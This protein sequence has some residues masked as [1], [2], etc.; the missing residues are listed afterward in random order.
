MLQMQISSADK[1]FR[2]MATSDLARELKSSH[3][4]LDDFETQKII[5]AVLKQLN[6]SSG[7]ISGLA[8]TCLGTLV[9]KVDAKHLDSMCAVL[10]D[11]MKGDKD[12]MRRDIA[13]LGVKTVIQ[14]IGVYE[15]ARVTAL[16][17]AEF[18]GPRLMACVVDDKEE[19]TLNGYDL[20]LVFLTQH[21]P[22][23]PDMCAIAD[24]CVG[25]FDN[26]RPGIRKKA[27]QCLGKMAASLPGKHFDGLCRK[28][29]E[30]MRQHPGTSAMNKV[31]TMMMAMSY[32]A[33]GAG[34]RMDAHI[35]E[36]LSLCFDFVGAAL[37][38]EDGVDLVESC[39]VVLEL[40]VSKCPG[41]TENKRSD[42]AKVAGRCIR[43]DPNYA[44]DSDMEEDEPLVDSDMG[45]KEE[46]EEGEDY[47]DEDAF[48][49][50]D[51]SS[52]KVRRAA[53]KLICTEVKQYPTHVSDLYD[54]L[55][56]ILIKRAISE[57]EDTVRQ[58]IFNSYLE[59]LKVVDADSKDDELVQKFDRDAEDVVVKFARLVKK[60]TVQT[61]CCV[62][63]ALHSMVVMRPA[64]FSLVLPKLSSDIV[65]CLQED[66]AFA[67]QVQ[68]LE[69][70]EAG[71]DGMPGP[72][73]EEDLVKISEEV[74]ECAKK[75]YFASAA[76]ALKTCRR[77]VHLIRPDVSQ[78]VPQNLAGLVLPLFLTI[79]DVL[80]VS[81]KPQEVKN[82]AIDCAAESLAW[83]GD[84]LEG[85][86]VEA[87]AKDFAAMPSN[88][89]RAKI[90]G[91]SE[92]YTGH[93]PRLK[94]VRILCFLKI[95]VFD[96]ACF[97]G[98]PLLCR[99]WRF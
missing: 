98:L 2:Y 77:L 7:D 95:F 73:N 52:W 25:E 31:Q 63:K 89:K 45:D 99:L 75:K 74:L 23:F 24:T 55:Q 14:N 50:D 46:Q 29:L 62:Y 6:D 34:Y 51:D 86:Q 79:S 9:G 27:M 91:P 47:D 71:F 20:L 3:L 48:S 93:L 44:A 38:D 58:D 60:Q 54:L 78:P 42:I 65:A 40:C 28:I 66:S 4:V 68:V 22:L 97:D 16:G 19:V 64:L 92:D 49:D 39:L 59:L 1:D 84:L 32:I 53:S 82:A 76:I 30:N 13:Y 26:A 12:G 94:D 18:L 17:A 80:S 10:L 43:Y 33:R 83:M 69:C 57:R 72:D 35:Q 21:G 5:S 41:S 56:P 96:C 36:L 87:L 67:L 90:Q 85:T 61:K 8:N 88:T 70:I 15:H 37:E 81:D 11:Q